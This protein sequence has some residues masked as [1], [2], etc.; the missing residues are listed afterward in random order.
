MKQN[1]TGTT[2]DPKARLVKEAPYYIMKA[3]YSQSIRA[4]QTFLKFLKFLQN[5]FC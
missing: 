2:Y 1:N 4:N 5:F 3:K